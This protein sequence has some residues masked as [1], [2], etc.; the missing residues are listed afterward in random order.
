MKSL[1]L[2]AIAAI[3][4]PALAQAGL[5]QCAVSS[6]LLGCRAFGHGVAQVIL[7]RSCTKAGSG[8]ALGLWALLYVLI[9][10]FCLNHS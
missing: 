3:A 10:V 8:N 6:Y 2:I 1:T 9:V 7:F 4:T 5:P